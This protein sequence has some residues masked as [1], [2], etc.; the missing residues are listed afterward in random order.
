MLLGRLRQRR[1][2]DATERELLWIVTSPRSGSTWLLNLLGLQPRVV[3]IDE[4]HIGV[5]L[6]VWSED[7]VSSPMGSAPT[8]RQ[9]WA[10]LR[11]GRGDYFFSEHFRGDWA[12]YLRTLILARFA[13]HAQRYGDSVPAGETPMVVAKEPMGAQGA[14][15]AL[16]VLPRA[17]VLHLVRDPRDVCASLLD[18]YRSG[19][20]LHA[21]FPDARFDAV[22]RDERVRQFALR[23]RVRTE[24]GLAAFDAHDPDRRLQLRYEDLRA[25]AEGR[26]TGVCEW[27]GLPCDGVGE[28]V[29]RLRFDGVAPDK[30]GEGQFRRAAR[31][32]Q[33]RDALTEEEA[34]VIEA[35]CAAP[36]ARLG[37]EAAG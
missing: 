17:R 8:E 13:A 29:E 3:M 37:Y 23:W 21:G 16:S 31:P 25:D 6:G 35:E 22:A 18:A 1:R 26:L 2:L 27:A 5:H 20:W 15:L 12:P 10:T 4:P 36:M 33:W 34:R 9:V 28:A 7:M 24:V 11:A 14:G 32:G 30:L 19:S